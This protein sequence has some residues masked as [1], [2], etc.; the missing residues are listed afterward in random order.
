MQKRMGTPARGERT[1]RAL[2]SRR[3]RT[4]L[5]LVAGVA[6]LLVPGATARA[7]FHEILVREV[8]AGGS[9]NDSYVVLQAYTSGQNFV[10]GHSVTGYNASGGSLGTFTFGDKVNNGQSQMTILVADT[11]YATGFPSGPSPD[12]TSASL[13]LE[14]AGGAVCWD[15]LDCVAWGNFSG[16]V[17][18]SPGAPAASPGGIA[19]GMALRRTISGGSCVGR[20]DLGDD[21][22]NSEADF[23]QQTPHPRNNASPI[24]ESATCTAP[25]LPVATID[26]APA[27]AT[28]STSA[29]FTYHS[30]PAGASFECKL[31]AA[32]FASCP[33]DGID[34][35]GP[36]TESNHTFQVRAKNANGTGSA[37]SHQW[38]VDNAA[39]TVTID[40]KPQDP[41]PGG[42]STFKFHASETVS[43]FEC[44]LAVGAAAD[45]FS[46]CTSPKSY[47]GL[48]DGEHTFKVRAV[49]PA[50]N[51][52]SPAAFPAGTFVW[53]VDNS[54]T[55]TTPPETKITSAPPDPSGSSTAAFAYE[56]NEPGSSFQCSLDG[57]AFVACPT[58]GT[59]YAGLANGTH[60]FRVRAID[61]SSNTDPTPAGHTFTVVL[62]LI[63]LPPP[64]SLP[65][66]SAARPVVPKT[67]IVKGPSARTR[68]RTP[69]FAFRST[70]LGGT[71]KCKLDGGPFKQCR[72]PL[73][74]K[75]LS[76]GSHVLQVRAIISGSADPSPAKAQFKVVKGR[77]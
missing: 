62:T 14:R 31:D 13:N 47:S 68:D 41:S 1:S 24:E 4:L 59:V 15:G 36:L 58:A 27:V 22:N 45:S 77:K 75:T 76:Y 10:G 51:Q 67:T 12:G 32:A 25:Q 72:S 53:T 28:K 17:S 61:P 70:P 74:T 54:L 7:A 42:T 18:P 29:S 55:D 21:S 71:F 38:K 43:K 35:P 19:A 69:T 6:F 66:A 46:T 9:A 34:Y 56:S 44:S 5:A 16:G 48:A 60:T 11:A 23:T 33:E 37:D 73:T 65:P 20:L 57:A 64:P 49:D 63:A 8:Y 39:P 30:T 2:A 26:T 3:C 40:E 50:G 52:S